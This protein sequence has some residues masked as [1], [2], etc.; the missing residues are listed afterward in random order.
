M[1]KKLLYSFL[2]GVIGIIVTIVSMPLHGAGHGNHIEIG[3]GLLF[4]GLI[5]V[6][7]SIFSF[8]VILFISAI[9]K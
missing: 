5:L 8:V 1:K 2:T 9:D 6:A 4:I 3:N 7:T